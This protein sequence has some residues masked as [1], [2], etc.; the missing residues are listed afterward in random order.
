[1]T[2]RAQTTTALWFVG[3][4]VLSL[5]SAV[6]LLA[7]TFLPRACPAVYPHLASCDAESR[8]PGLVVGLILVV[9]ACLIALVASGRGSRVES[10]SYSAAL[11]AQVV[12]L[13]ISAIVIEFSSRILWGAVPL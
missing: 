5:A 3:P 12:V 6:V 7:I 8:I 13:V 10:H 2:Q 1:M 9:I 11:I 4:V